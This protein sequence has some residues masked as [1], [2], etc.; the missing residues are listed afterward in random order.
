[1]IDKQ[2]FH[3]YDKATNKPVKVCM[4]VDELEQ[5]L[6]KKEVD[7]AHWEVQPCYNIPSSEEQSY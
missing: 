5:M 7:F 3:I 2:M 6:A 4:T 1:M